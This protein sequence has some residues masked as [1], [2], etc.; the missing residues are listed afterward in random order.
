MHEVPAPIH[1]R[2]T[3][4]YDIMYVRNSIIGT[5]SSGAHPPSQ[6]LVSQGGRGVVVVDSGWVVGGLPYRDA[7]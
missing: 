7:D 1:I 6:Q 4:T 2:K 5:R 3:H